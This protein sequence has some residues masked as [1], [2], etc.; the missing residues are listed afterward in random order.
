M[1][2]KPAFKR[3]EL[4]PP[5]TT[6]GALPPGAGSG[7]QRWNATKKEPGPARGRRIGSMGRHFS[8]G[9]LVFPL[10]HPL[11]QRRLEGPP[12]EFQRRDLGVSAL[13]FGFGLGGATRRHKSALLVIPDQIAGRFQCRL[14]NVKPGLE[15]LFGLGVGH[16]CPPNCDP[17]LRVR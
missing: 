10:A 6:P 14:T 4:R 8:P 1:L 16:G 5:S 11:G 13:G 2:P 9:A 7:S 3:C 12:G 15:L 17:P